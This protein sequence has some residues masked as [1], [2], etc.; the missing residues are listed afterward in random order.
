MY[1]Y[2]TIVAFKLW[3]PQRYYSALAVAHMGSHIRTRTLFITR[4]TGMAAVE[5]VMLEKLDCV[6]SKIATRPYMHG[7]TSANAY[8][9]IYV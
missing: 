1:I 6:L 8:V 9:L 5:I 3:Q 4:L 7:H 2:G